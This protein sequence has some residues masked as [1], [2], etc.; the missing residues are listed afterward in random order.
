[1]FVIIIGIIL[2][3]LFF[4]WYMWFLQKK[5]ASTLNEY[6]DR[7]D[8]LKEA[9]LEGKIE[10]LTKMKLSG[11]SDD[12]FNQLKVEYHKQEEEIFSDILR[13]M[14]GA[15]YK[16]TEFKVFGANSDLKKI[17]AS[18]KQ[19]EDEIS[20]ISQGFDEL[21]KSNELNATHSEELQ[22]KYQTLRK[23]VLTQSFSY[24]PATDKLEDELSEIA[25]LLDNEKQLTTKGDHIEASQILDDIKIK[26]GLIT[27]QL[28]VIEPLFHDLN[29]VFPGQVD[30]IKFVFQKLDKQHF[31]FNDDIVAL[32]QEVQKEIEESNDKLGELN[33]DAVN[34]N[35]EDIKQ[36][37]DDLYETLT[38]EIDGKRDV[39][40]EQK[41]VLD[42]INHAVFQH[43][44]LDKRI[45]K[46]QEG[47]VLTDKTLDTFK[48]NFDTL[49][50]VRREYDADVQSIADKQVIF[51]Q[52]RTDFK[53]IVK[54]LDEIETSEKDINDELNQ[55]L[56]SEQIA[57]NSV[58]EYAKRLEIQKKMIEQLRLN[59]LPDDY[60]DYF[61]MVY[62]EINKLY[63][64]LDAD[65]I[66]MEDISK[67]VIITQ[68]DLNN[69]V[70]KTSKLKYNVQLAE[71]LLQY[72]NRYAT[73]DGAFSD[74]L[75]HAR[76]LFDDDY[77]YQES[78]DVISKALEEVESGSVD[79][80][81]ETINS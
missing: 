42:Y 24:G 78:V 75:A 28:K 81:K 40:K 10:K 19:F 70:E 57:R 68:E 11:A 38:L 22:K 43:N 65:Q 39:L 33:F 72:A 15:E 45:Q 66:N 47:Y 41:P 69:L 51:S 76:S 36:R 54:E 56:T 55:M 44:R 32:I 8:H 74:E 62:D 21:L 1:M 79:R 53:N 6:K 50:E 67:A 34:T 20:Q 37:I 52:V 13:Q 29:E 5:N 18:L 16:N 35:N 25:N 48:S 7:T 23:Q 9:R 80:I 17:N 27:D 59:G 26:L 64:D 63:D 31:K 30:E 4:L 49:N 12:R 60:L 58:D 71:K 46:L 14:R 61:Y 3:V 2:I 73:K 77:N